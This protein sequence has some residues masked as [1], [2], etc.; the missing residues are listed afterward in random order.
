MPRQN[1]H[2]LFKNI[3]TLQQAFPAYEL[4]DAQVQ[5]ADAVNDV[6]R[7]GGVLFVEA[8]TG[9]GKTLAYLLP[10]LLSGKRVVVS[11]ATK[12]LQDQ[13]AR[14]DLPLIEKLF[15]RPLR[16]VTLKGR[17]NYLC[18][19]RLSRFK[20]NPLFSFVE[21][22]SLY[23]PFLAWSQETEMGDREELVN[24]PEHLGFWE[25]VNSKSDLCIGTQCPFF[26]ECFITR[27]KREAAKV[28]LL[29][30]NHHLFFSDLALRQK[31]PAEV[32]PDYDGVIFDEAHRIEATATLFFGHQIGY[33]QMEELVRD[34]ERWS[35]AKK[36]GLAPELER[37]SRKMARFFSF[38][39]PE[40]D[41][42]PLEL[43]RISEEC[44]EAGRQILEGLEHLTLRLHRESLSGDTE[45]EDEAFHKR[46]IEL[47]EGIGVFLSPPKPDFVYW[48][49]KRKR[50]VLLHA[51]PVEIGN[52][53][54]EALYA[55]VHFTIFT[56]A[57]LSAGGSFSF[58]QDRLGVP[59]TARTLILPSPFDYEKRVKIFI[60][61]SFPVPGTQEYEIALPDLIRE[62]IIL[63]GGR[64]LTLF[65]S[66]R[67]MRR[68]YERIHKS[69]PYPLFLQGDQPRS[70]LLNMF[71]KEEES[72][73][74]A[75][76]SFWEG[77]DVPG[78]SLTAVVIDKL[79]FFAPDDPLEIARMKV[80]EKRGKNPFFQYQIPRAIISLKQGLGRLMRHKKDRGVLAI[81]D[82]R[83]YRRSYGGMFLKSLPPAEI[84]HS[85]EELKGFIGCFG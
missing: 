17:Q 79:P 64:T 62:I 51:S 22:A 31:A 72:V 39:N 20:K 58:V 9:T 70:E 1:L 68:V 63:N 40:S 12:N 41:R 43:T 36:I 84:I 18:K 23:K 75:T 61:K 15:S 11:T 67:Q 28:D 2:D 74:F 85:L 3:E 42:F 14:K 49:E 7:R 34:L 65:T 80:I 56:S 33:G 30:V 4:R 26:K 21:E 32:L 27:L 73:L 78:N 53:L 37:L 57:T 55:Q 66:Y 52:I 25:E 83:I 6:M 19:R 60:P 38:F 8:A 44:F 5:M 46:I 29:I 48:G 47:Q 69:V 77:V 81:L 76:A 16:Y 50:G 71:R 54:Q 82:S 24:F 35:N 10:A 13:I 59:E 45:G